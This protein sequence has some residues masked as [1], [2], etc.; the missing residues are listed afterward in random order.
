M[1]LESEI[2]I[3]L[4]G[5]K[6]ALENPRRHLLRWI[7][8]EEGVMDFNKRT[9]KN[10]K[11]FPFKIELVASHKLQEEAQKEFLKRQLEFQ[12]VP[13][14]MFAIFEALETLEFEELKRIITSSDNLKIL[15][16]DQIS[17][18]HNGAAILR[19]AAFY[20]IDIV[21]L[22][23]EKSFSLT[24]SFYRIA[25]G[26]PEYLKFYRTPHLS[27]TLGQLKDLGV[28]LIGL[29]EHAESAIDSS[30]L[31]SDKMA[32]VLGAEDVGLSNAVKRQMDDLLAIKPRGIIKSL[33]VSTAAAVALQICFPVN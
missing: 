30:V 15:A 22:P 23:Q 12:R 18:V 8:T 14:Q 13:S 19:T 11:S 28:K 2:I 27:R 32:L 29:S 3:G 16:L 4:H 26:A 31:N 24:P 33:N 7:A 10:V 21:L 9:G 20:G 25:S 5:I 1:E 17:D 6:A